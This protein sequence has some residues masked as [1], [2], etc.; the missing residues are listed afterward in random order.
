[1]YSELSPGMSTKGDIIEE[2][3][4]KRERHVPFKPL[5]K[6]SFSFPVYFGV[7]LQSLSILS[8]FPTSPPSGYTMFNVDIKVC[9]TELLVKIERSDKPDR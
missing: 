9:L 3:S 1:M 2:V 7:N 4:T 8:S 5:R 6:V